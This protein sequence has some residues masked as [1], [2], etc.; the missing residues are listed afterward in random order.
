VAHAA[1]G[2]RGG[3]TSPGR[4]EVQRAELVNTDHP[5]VGREVVVQVEDAQ[6]PGHER[7]SFDAFK[8]AADSFHQDLMAGPCTS[9]R[10]VQLLGRCVGSH[11]CAAVET[12]AASHG[13]ARPPA[14]AL[15]RP[16][17]ASAVSPQSSGFAGGGVAVFTGVRL[18]GAD[19]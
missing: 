13:G 17:E 3:P 18:P 12:L 9:T 2:Q 4:G 14:E 19:A 10:P 6:H 8:A 15:H 7:G 1:A 16:G 11:V 5:P